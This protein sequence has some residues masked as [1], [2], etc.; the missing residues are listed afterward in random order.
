VRDGH[1][2]DQSRSPDDG[3]VPALELS[4]HKAQELGSLIV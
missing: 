2:L 1:E 3:V 4:Y